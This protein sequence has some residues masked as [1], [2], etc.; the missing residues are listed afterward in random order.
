MTLYSN[1]DELGLVRY[2]ARQPILTA[3]Q[4]VIG[5][6]LL[7]RTGVR[8][9]FSGNDSEDTGRSVID[10]S[11][12]LGLNTLC[13][14]R[15]AF[16][17][18]TRDILLEKYLTLLPSEKV[19]A[20]IPNTV[21]LDGEVLETCR[22]LKDAGYK[23]ALGDF[24]ID[25]AREPFVGL[26]D[27]IKVDIKQTSLGNAAKIAARYRTPNSRMLADGVETWE[28]FDFTKRAG[29]R[30]FQGYFF[31]KPEIVRT[32][33]VSSN[34]AAC[35]Q[36][37]QAVSRPEL[38]WEEVEDII[39]RD[40]TLYYRLLRYLNS[41]AFGLRSEARSVRQA[42]MILGENEFRRWCRLAVMFDV[43][44]SRP[45]DLVLSA[46]VRARF[47]ELIGQ[48]VEHGDVDLFLLGLLSLMDAILELPMRQVL[49]GLP[50]DLETKTLLLEHNGRLSPLY[51][52]L[53]AVEAGAWGAVVRLCERLELQ[54]EFVAESH[55]SAMEWAQTIATNA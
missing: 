42:L 55:Q 43:S 52:L 5:Y 39:K 29:F 24:V 35:L 33:G 10:V 50:L 7:F 21:A 40:A 8:S 3:N 26:A 6:K 30:Y 34:R 15:L 54:E 47:G 18:C 25:D 1:E 19:V 48:K 37:L 14:N 9:F 2:A 38:N 32:R 12:L 53:F 31:R 45:S 49:E 36:L 20:E 4:K 13:D 44:Q 22:E 41:A 16:I 11:T 27:F 17:S 28:D 46:L 23:I 51:D